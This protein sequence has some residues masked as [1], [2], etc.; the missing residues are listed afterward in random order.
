MDTAIQ[1]MM[2]AIEKEMPSLLNTNTSEGRKFINLVHPYLE[3]EKEQI[4][5]A[6]FSGYE[7]CRCRTLEEQ[8]NDFETEYYNET[9]KNK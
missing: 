7:Y 1:K 4:K 2:M 6:Y 9:F 5:D 3:M 8:D